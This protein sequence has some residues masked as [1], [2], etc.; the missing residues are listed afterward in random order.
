M[1]LEPAALEGWRQ[2]RAPADPPH[3]L[4]SAHTKACYFGRSTIRESWC[5]RARRCGG[6]AS[7]ATM[8][9][10]F[11]RAGH[12]QHKHTR[13]HAHAHGVRTRARAHTHTHTQE[14]A[15]THTASRNRR[16]D[17][18]LGLRSA[19][20]TSNKPPKRAKGRRPETAL[21]RGPRRQSPCPPSSYCK[22]QQASR[23]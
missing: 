1:G 21:G 15:R 19:V 12:T 2:P 11:C 6:K 22:P 4:P 18:L 20:H 13:T 16:S 14:P 8:R 23:G 7:P 3:P 5:A 17:Q 10:T 9:G